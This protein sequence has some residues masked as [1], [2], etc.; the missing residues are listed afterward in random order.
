[1]PHPRDPRLNRGRDGLAMTSAPVFARSPDS[2][3]RRSNLGGDDDRTGTPFAFQKDLFRM[4]KGAASSCP[5]LYKSPSTSV[6]AGRNNLYVIAGAGKPTWQPHRDF[7]VIGNRAEMLRYCQPQ[8]SIPGGKASIITS[9]S[10]VLPAY[11][12]Q[13][14]QSLEPT[15]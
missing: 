10:V 12:P 8:R 1:V 5:L 11:V 2:S 14:S 9:G 6:A 15:T 13:G 7:P 4:L 3:G